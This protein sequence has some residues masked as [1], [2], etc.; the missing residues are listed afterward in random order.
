LG[1]IIC[2]KRDQPA[3]KSILSRLMNASAIHFLLRH[4]PLFS[5]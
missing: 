3:E 5:P 2:G 1:G 4:E